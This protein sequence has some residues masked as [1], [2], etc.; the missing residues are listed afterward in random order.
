MADIDSIRMKSKLRR[1][2]ESLNL[3]KNEDLITNIDDARRPDGTFEVFKLLQQLN[4]SQQYLDAIQIIFNSYESEASSNAMLYVDEIVYSGKNMTS[5][6]RVKRQLN[7]RVDTTNSLIKELVNLESETPY[8]I[9][10]YLLKK[11]FSDFILYHDGFNISDS[12]EFRNIKV[13]EQLY[14][15]YQLFLNHYIEMV[16][17][18]NTQKL[19]PTDALV[20]GETNVGEI[21]IIRYNIV[22]RSL[23][24]RRGSHIVV[25]RKQTVGGSANFGDEYL[26]SLGITETQKEKL[27]EASEHGMTLVF[28]ETGSGKTTLI[29]YMANYHIENK[30]NLIT[31]EDTAELGL[32]VPLALTTNNGHGIK[33]LFTAALRQNPS[34][35]IIGETRTEEI[36]DIM[37]ASLSTSLAMSTIHANTLQ[38]AIARIIVMAEPRDMDSNVLEMLMK[39]SITNFI[40]MNRRKIEGMWTNTGKLGGPLEETWVPVE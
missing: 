38:R 12:L 26:D 20:D 28:G 29:R 32:N 30:R 34:G 25:L 14:D 4:G 31:I 10:A 40:Y 13:P 39:S 16:K 23:N 37:E 24:G 7:D 9:F 1:Q 11:D 36:V 8:G 21:G 27:Q 15:I 3:H 6:N 2:Q 18:I 5:S 17:A 22:E 35:I 33:D 19:N